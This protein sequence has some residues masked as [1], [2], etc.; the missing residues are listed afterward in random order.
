MKAPINSAPAIVVAPIAVGSSDPEPFASGAPGMA[1]RHVGGSPGFIDEHETLGY[2]IEWT[3]AAAPCY[4]KTGKL[5]GYALQ[6]SS[7]ISF[8][9]R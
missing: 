2:K 9:E 1:A 4:W 7:A 6:P 8:A 5:A 3:K